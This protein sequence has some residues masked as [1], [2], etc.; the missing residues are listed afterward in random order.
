MFG[1]RRVAEPYVYVKFLIEHKLSII[2]QIS[3]IW[4]SLPNENVIVIS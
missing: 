1:Q 4:F 3:G 2:W